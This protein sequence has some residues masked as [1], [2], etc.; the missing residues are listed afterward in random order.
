V[1]PVK[2]GGLEMITKNV[3]IGPNAD[4][5]FR[6]LSQFNV[7]ENYLR[8]T[9][10]EKTKK[11]L[12]ESTNENK[13]REGDERQKELIGMLML[14]HRRGI[15]SH[16]SGPINYSA[17]PFTDLPAKLVRESVSY[18]DEAGK[19]HPYK[20]G[21]CVVKEGKNQWLTISDKHVFHN[22]LK[23]SLTAYNKA[24]PNNK[25]RSFSQLAEMLVPNDFSAHDGSS[26]SIGS[27]S[28]MAIAAGD[29]YVIKQTVYDGTEVGKVVKVGKML[30]G[31]DAE[32]F[33]YKVPDQ[34]LNDYTHLNDEDFFNPKEKVVGVLRTYKPGFDKSA[35]N[36]FVITPKD[37]GISKEVIAQ[38][39]PVE[40]HVAA[41]NPIPL[42]AAVNF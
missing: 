37:L 17:I 21:G 30:E 18:V 25:L 19:K 22:Y 8:R 32:F 26:L 31:I 23:K 9:V 38:Y 35:R 15:Q 5:I 3:L 2:E 36:E 41:H 29:S 10:A 42:K 24:N 39:F 33:L 4:P 1:E 34:E 12:S 14:K 6:A 13:V 27:K 7:L 40:L 16:S 11:G 28:L 20:D